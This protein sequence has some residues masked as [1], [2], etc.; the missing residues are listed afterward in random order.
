MTYLAKKYAAVV[1][2]EARRHRPLFTHAHF[3]QWVGKL[4]QEEKIWLFLCSAGVRRQN[5]LDGL[6]VLSN[7]F[8][9]PKILERLLTL[10]LEKRLFH[11][12]PDISYY[13]NLLENHARPITLTTAIAVTPNQRQHFYYTLKTYYQCD[14]VI[15]YKVDP[16]IYGGCVIFSQGQCIDA[17]LRAY[18]QEMKSY[19][20]AQV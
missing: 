11:L 13:F 17:S 7:I 19:L 4:Q 6:R 8:S 10:L 9:F 5:V 15:R 18:L 2:E 16:R 14:V 12:L 3:A 20:K 1:F